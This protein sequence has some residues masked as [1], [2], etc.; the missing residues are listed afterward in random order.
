[1]LHRFQYVSPCLNTTKK[2]ILTRK[3]GNVQPSQKRFEDAEDLLDEDS[4]QTSD[5]K[6]KKELS[7]SSNV[8]LT[9]ISRHLEAI[10]MIC[11]QG[12]RVRNESYEI[13]ER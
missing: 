5:E 6:T 12:N 3:I 9:T 4:S 10:G 1:M 2:V 11:K 13:Q 7:E 8:D